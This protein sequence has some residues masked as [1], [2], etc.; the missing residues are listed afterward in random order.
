MNEINEFKPVPRPAFQD[1]PFDPTGFPESVEEFE[2]NYEKKHPNDSAIA[3]NI[4]HIV[5]ED[6]DGN[7]VDEAFGLNIMTDYGFSQKHTMTDSYYS[8]LSG[9]YLGDGEW[10]GDLDPASKVLVHPISSTSANM[11]Y[12]G[13]SHNLTKWIPEKESNLV[14]FK[15]CEGYFDYT[16]WS[17]DHTV[18]EIGIAYRN[19]DINNLV[20]HAAV[21]DAQGERTTFVKKVNQKLTITVWGRIMVPIV[22][23]VNSSWDRGI[24][25][26]INSNSFCQLY[27]GNYWR[28]LTA[29]FYPFDWHDG[30]WYSAW[31]VRNY[32][33]GS[34]TD[35]VY[36]ASGTCGMNIFIDGRYQY[37]SDIL[38]N[39]SWSSGRACQYDT[40]YIFATKLKMAEPIPFET[41]K[42]RL[43]GY[44][45]GSTS[46]TYCRRNRDTARDPNGQLPMTD[47]HVTSLSMYNGQTDD[48]DIDVPIYEPYPYV[49]HGIFLLRLRVREYNYITFL[50]RYEWYTVY[51]NES[52][53]FPIKSISN[54]SR[55]FY[56]TDAYWDSST[57]EIVPNNSS[58]SREQ[59]SKRYFIMFE[60]SFPWRSDDWNYGYYGGEYY[61]RNVSR[62]D[63][64]LPR[65]DVNN[66]ISEDTMDF[67]RPTNNS[68]N[69][70]SRIYAESYYSGKYVKN[71][72]IGY[73][74]GDGFIMYPD[75]FSLD[76][77]QT[78]IL[79]NYSWNNYS[80]SANFSGYNHRYPMGGIDLPAVPSGYNND[81]THPGMIWNT[82][83]GTHIANCGYNSWSRGVR[84]YTPS[85]DPT[86]APSYENFTFDAA[87]SDVPAMTDTQNGYVVFSYVSGANNA[88][89]TY[90]VEYDVEGVAPNMY[91]VEGYHHG[92]AIDLTNY[93][94]AI[95]AS[96]TDH[97]HMVVYDMANRTIHAEFDLPEG[98]TFQG[99]AGWKDYVYIRVDQSGAKST[100]L[101]YI[102]SG[103]YENTPLNIPQMRLDT[104]SY[105]AHIQRSVPANG[106]IESCMVLLASDRDIDNENHVFFKESDPTHSVQ[107]IRNERCETSN[108]IRW[109]KAW[110]GYSSDNKQLILTYAG[111][112]N[113]ALDLGWCLKHGT[114]STHLTWGDLY[115]E[116]SNTYTPIY[117]K[118]YIYC[119]QLYRYEYYDEKHRFRHRYW[120]QP[121]QQWLNL[122]IVGTTYT[123]NSMMNPVRIQGNFATWL[124]QDTNRGTD[125]APEPYVP[126]QEEEEDPPL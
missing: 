63:W 35:H 16:V 108:Y 89:C 53:E 120:R 4:Y 87:W 29:N 37:V 55:T 25:C 103:I 15:L 82:T 109:Q 68:Y 14:R 77:P 62:Y 86:E 118:G 49:E 121:V 105:Y 40:Y 110:L 6:L 66:R 23:I 125:V 19:G 18:T 76:T 27:Y 113:I 78:N 98:Y 111:R 9:L 32:D 114:V 12:T 39:S 83:R 81:G 90:V 74:A 116:S 71:E 99:G 91:K 93:F 3:H 84:V 45:S 10:S 73:I 7:I 96:V 52:Q 38:F 20:F 17:E 79:G 8:A 117:Y 47:I 50:N 13:Y 58:I 30:E 60:D 100:F 61:T 2:R 122:K 70:Y 95:D 11:T 80:K 5:A 65:I 57:W 92:W 56:V 54:A 102:N 48:F 59:G 43:G 124:Y 94:V 28:V 101:Y 107:L 46:G 69:Y 119:M 33:T 31:Y 75:D 115:D 21:Y 123:P 34:I 41:D 36:N 44:N 26:V 85:S 97:L 88:N 112:R 64:T 1:I 72:T 22:K 42:Y 67:G 24:P 104:T 126:P 106:N 51:I